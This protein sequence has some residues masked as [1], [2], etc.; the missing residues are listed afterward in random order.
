MSSSTTIP[1]PSVEDL[2]PPLLAHIPI[3]F[4][5]PQAPPSLLPLLAPILRSRVRLLGGG[6]DAAISAPEE[7]WLALMTWSEDGAP[8]FG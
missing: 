4:T 7:S 1:P 6:N 3:A 8:Q 2:L 5:S